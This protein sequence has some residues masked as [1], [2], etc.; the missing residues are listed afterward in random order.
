MLTKFK[1]GK[2]YSYHSPNEYVGRVG[3]QVIKR[4]KCFLFLKPAWKDGS[5]KR[6][7]TIKNEIETCCAEPDNRFKTV[8]F[9]KADKSYKNVFEGE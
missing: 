4:T 6:K 5:F 2:F 8:C 9:I 3:W 1:V 7:I